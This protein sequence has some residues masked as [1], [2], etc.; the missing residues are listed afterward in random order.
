MMTKSHDHYQTCKFGFVIKCNEY[1][2][3]VNLE[4]RAGQ[5]MHIGHH[6]P[7]NPEFISLPSRLMSDE[8]K[9]D[10]CHAMDAQTSKAAGRNFIF[11]KFG[12]Y[13]NSIKIAYLA[14]SAKDKKSNGK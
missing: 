10:A 11:G 9:R 6:R 1:G 12:K 8:M 3:Y 14:S 4:R 2:Y 13:I 5:H 7:I